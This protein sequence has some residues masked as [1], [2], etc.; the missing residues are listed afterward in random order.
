M[1]KSSNV[2]SSV[3]PGRRGVGVNLGDEVSHERQNGRRGLF[4][5]HQSGSS[6]EASGLW[7]ITPELP[8]PW[9]HPR[10][11][12]ALPETDEV[13]RCRRTRSTQTMNDSMALPP[14]LPPRP[15]R[16]DPEP[17]PPWPVRAQRHH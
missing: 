10:E 17:T 16:V 8:Q 14:L 13:R 3:T 4:G 12:D 7:H 15:G 9:V 5:R 1:L 6:P 11:M 2:L